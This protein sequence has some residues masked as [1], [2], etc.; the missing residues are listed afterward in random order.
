MP[1]TEQQIL[2]QLRR[3]ILPGTEMS[4][5]EAGRVHRVAV[6]DSAI[7]VE[8]APSTPQVDAQVKAA[9][10][11]ALREL[12]GVETVA[13]SVLQPQQSPTH[14]ADEPKLPG[15]RHVV[16]VASGK[17]GVGKS[18]VAV[19][20]AL[21]LAEAGHSVGLLDADIYGPS[22]QLMMAIDAEP[23]GT[24]DGKIEPLE[25]TRGV[26]VMSIGYIVDPDQ[27]V[28]WRGPMLQKALEQFLGDVLWG[29]L[30]VLVTDL[31]PG[32]GDVAI[33]LC[34]MVPI[35]GAVIV[36]TPQEVALI[37]ARKGLGMFRRLDVP[38]LGIVENM[39]DYVCPS[40]GHRETIFGSGGGRRTADEL[41][42]PFLGSVP[43]DP[44]IVAGSDHGRP[45]LLEHPESVSAQALRS[46]ADEVAK[47]LQ[48]RFAGGEV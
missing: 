2:D 36:T 15:V 23:K 5:V 25:G 22:Q 10:E 48:E 40:C 30:D 14:G 6:D 38:V 9:I 3:V 21:A 35:A 45:V 46:V 34:Q 4:I 1:A 47:R 27:P 39:S 32:T 41:E 44:A 7:T 24:K 43:L 17:G 8:I 16:A 26:K 12:E 42:I 29:Q 11:A 19:N 31:P 28:I 20:L 18:T 37:D 33:S 13:V